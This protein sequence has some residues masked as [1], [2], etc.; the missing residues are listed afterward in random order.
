[1]EN[2]IKEQQLDL[3][4]DRTSTAKLWSNQLRLYFSAFAYVLLQALRRLGLH[5]TEMAH[6]QCGTIRLRLLKIGALLTIS[7]RQLRVSW[8]SGYPYAT[9]FQQVYAQLRC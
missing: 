5:G 8:A 7:V 9:L 2:R 1:M 4:A 3:Y 6:A